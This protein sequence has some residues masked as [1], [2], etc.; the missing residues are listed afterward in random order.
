MKDNKDLNPFANKQLASIDIVFENCEVY[1]IPADGIYK[2]SVGDINFSFDVHVN[3]LSKYTKP[4]EISSFSSTNYIWLVL[5]Q[6]G[7]KVESGWED[8]FDET[9]IFSDRVKGNDITHIDFIFNDGSHLYVEVPWKDGYSEFVNQY[10]HTDVKEKFAFIDISKDI[11]EEE[12]K[13]ENNDLYD[14][15]TFTPEIDFSESIKN[16]NFD[17]IEIL[18]IDNEDEESFGEEVPNYVQA[19]FRQIDEELSRVMWNINQE[20]FDSPF[21]NTGNKFKN[22]VFEIEA[23]SWDEEYDQKYN[24]KWGDYKVRWYKHS[25][26]DPEAN[27]FISPEECAQMLNECLESIRKMD[28]DDLIDISEDDLPEFGNVYHNCVQCRIET[29][30]CKLLQNGKYACYD[31]LNNLG[32]EQK[33]LKEELEDSLYE[34]GFDTPEDITDC[35]DTFID[36]IKYTKD[37][38]TI[39]T[40]EHLIKGLEAINTTLKMKNDLLDEETKQKIQKMIENW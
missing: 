18:T 24:F 34:F 15:E 20:E 11:N 33:R 35:I 6:K 32:K 22:D 14:F 40:I 25:R 4:G 36:F 7:M 17:N 37:N 2:L 13:Q 29:D 26:R 9:Q 16:G 27:R 28:I 30:N 31:C 38:S 5:N 23:Y 10:Q 8:I 21:D 1:N 3:G 12:F 19:A 39:E